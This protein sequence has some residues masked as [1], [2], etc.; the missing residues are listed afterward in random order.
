MNRQVS[1]S[2][3]PRIKVRPAPGMLVTLL[4]AL[5]LLGMLIMFAI[6]VARHFWVIVIAMMQP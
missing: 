1:A 4:L 6:D 5:L 3:R 2:L